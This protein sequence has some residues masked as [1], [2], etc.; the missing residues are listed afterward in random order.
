MPFFSKGTFSEQVGEQQNQGGSWLT[1]VYLRMSIK[2]SVC[3]CVHVK[4]M[5]WI[6]CTKMWLHLC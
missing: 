3:V 5:V 1:K 4:V 2:A 6:W